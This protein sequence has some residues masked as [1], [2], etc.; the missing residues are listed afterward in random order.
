ME[1]GTSIVLYQK[2]N[3]YKNNIQKILNEITPHLI[4]LEIDGETLFYYIKCLIPLK[5][6]LKKDG[7]IL[8]N[9]LTQT[10][11]ANVIT[12][13]ASNDEVTIDYI[14]QY[15]KDNINT[16][17]KRENIEKKIE[18]KRTKEQQVLEQKLEKIKNKSLK[19][20]END[21]FIE[22]ENIIPQHIVNQTEN[23]SQFIE[24]STEDNPK[25]KTNGYIPNPNLVFDDEP[26]P[27]VQSIQEMSNEEYY[28]LNTIKINEYVE[29][30][31]LDDDYFAPKKSGQKVKVPGME[32]FA[33]FGLDLEMERE[34]E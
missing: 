6:Q 24:K 27:E 1:A 22:F 10:N 18:E 26:S 13:K 7:N 21:E 14:L 28:G 2:Q 12:L 5:W 30:V 32:K 33:Q 29:P 25:P 31:P 9:K 16:N 15:L 17:I 11:E 3:K 34:A 19:I 4:S 20:K 8:V 23:N